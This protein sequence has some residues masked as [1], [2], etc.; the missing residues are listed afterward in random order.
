[1]H[2]KITLEA[3]IIESLGIE[4]EKPTFKK[5]KY[6]YLRHSKWQLHVFSFLF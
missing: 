4:K 2:I 1:V 6:P 3:M 5:A